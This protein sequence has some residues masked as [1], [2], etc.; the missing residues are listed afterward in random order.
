MK[1]VDDLIRE[2]QELKLEEYPTNRIKELILDIGKIGTII[3]TLH[4]GKIVYRA[5]LTNGNE[6]FSKCSD[7]SFVPGDKNTKY[8]RASTPNNTMFYGSILPEIINAGE[9]SE[10]RVVGAF[11]CI[12]FLRNTLLDGE[13]KITFGKW[14]VTKDI[15]LLA[16]VHHADFKNKSDYVREMKNGFDAFIAKFP[17]M[18]ERT[19]KIIGYLASEFAKKTTE[20]DYDYLIT[21]LFTERMIEKELA[22]VLYPSVRTDGDGFNVAIHPKFVKSSMKLSAVGV[23]TVYKKGKRSIVDNESVAFLKDGDENFK[24]EPVKNKY[25]LGREKVLIELNQ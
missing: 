11:E 15:P 17:E 19:T 22:G 10:I 3:N 1:N 16:I 13:Q 20:N 5:R 21:S 9:L 4:E 23:C 7:L 6:V 18:T 2:F 24:L 12:P 25:H 8:Q 14:T